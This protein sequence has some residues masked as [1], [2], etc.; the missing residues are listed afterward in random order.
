MK[1][2]LNQTIKEK[3]RKYA[4]PFVVGLISA[5]SLSGCDSSY[6]PNPPYYLIGQ[7]KVHFE[8][9]DLG[10]DNILT[11]IKPVGTEIDYEDINDDFKIDFV[12]VIKNGKKIEDLSVYSLKTIEE[13]RRFAKRQEEFDNYLEKLNRAK[14][15]TLNPENAHVEFVNND[16]LLD[17][18][19]KTGEIYLQTK[20][21]NFV[22][23]K[24]VLQQEKSKLDS[25]YR[26]KADS[27]KEILQQEKSKFDSAYQAKADSLKRVYENKLE[28]EVKIK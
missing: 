20:E 16:S 19:Y 21:G 6:I 18:V 25:A 28:K 27:L 10:D 3:T 17:I 7:D 23:Y 14:Y 2:N 22:S 9:R 11:V 26:A 4:F 15:E 24:N 13:R 12:E 8:K 5:L 1:L